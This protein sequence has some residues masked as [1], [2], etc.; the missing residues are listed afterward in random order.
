MDDEA[1]QF[2]I[3]TNVKHIQDMVKKL[4]AILTLI[5]DHF[6]RA[7]TSITTSGALPLPLSNLP[8]L[9]PLTPL[10]SPLG[11]PVPSQLEPSEHPISVYN[12]P[13][14]ESSAPP[15]ESETFERSKTFLR[16]QFHT[17]LSIFDRTILR[18]FKSRYTQFLIFWYTS[19]DPEFADVF[20]GML[21]DR[22]LFENS[23]DSTTQNN[24]PAVTRAAAAS[25]LGSF[26]SRAVF[27]DR[28]GAR[29]VVAVLCE[30]LKAHLEAVEELVRGGEH[31]V[32]GMSQNTVFYAVTQAV[33]LIFCFRWRDLLEDE[34]EEDELLIGKGGKKWM[35]QLNVL[36]RVVTSILNPLRVSFTRCLFLPTKSDI[37]GQV[38][39]PNVVMQFAR[40][41]HA[42]DFIYC[43]TILESNKR[44]EYGPSTMEGRV[45]SVT[46]VPVR[47]ASIAFHPIVLGG[48]INAELNTFFPF[49]PYRLPKSNVYIQAVYREWSAVA[50]DEEDDE[51][52]E[53]E[54]YG[55]GDP[56][57]VGSS[58]Q[59]KIPRSDNYGGDEDG[60][61]ESLGK[62]SISPMRPPVHTSLHA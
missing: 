8:P 45:M 24:T 21:V 47:P 13:P 53:E 39:S 36:Q 44:S 2:E 20:Q 48:S 51:D 7:Y 3:A 27:V 1:Q 55:D 40:V 22:A 25:Y 56:S 16:T 61:G 23:A 12:T 62:M 33:F 9:P 38:C 17:L 58:G 10:S 34:Q 59:L 37:F 41:A 18:T 42:T 15:S 43:Y 19:L 46:S 28:E 26:V 6:H 57:D 14:P 54:D 11:T 52:E 32:G 4:D 60:L 49:D 35:P 50:I 29:R 31:V 5:F 30:F